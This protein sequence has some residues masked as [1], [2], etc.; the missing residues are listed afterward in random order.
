ME[1]QLSTPTVN[2]TTVKS[3]HFGVKYITIYPATF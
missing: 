3:K 1:N 2:I